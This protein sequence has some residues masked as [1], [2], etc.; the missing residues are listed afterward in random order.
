MGPG[1]NHTQEP[2]KRRGI[3]DIG[4]NLDQEHTSA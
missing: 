1:Y 3:Q 4:Y 2:S